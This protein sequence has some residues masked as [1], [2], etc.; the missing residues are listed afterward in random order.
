MPVWY[1]DFH[2]FT[3]R[4]VGSPLLFQCIGTPHIGFLASVNETP[5]T[6]S[7]R[8]E[9]WEISQFLFICQAHPNDSSENITNSSTFLHTLSMNQEEAQTLTN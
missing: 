1:T 3:R 9:T 6:Y 8:T 5:D 7:L 2:H 4:A